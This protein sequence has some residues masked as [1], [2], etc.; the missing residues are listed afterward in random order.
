MV[1]SLRT[2]LNGCTLLAKDSLS[3]KAKYEAKLNADVLG[4]KKGSKYTK[5]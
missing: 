5:V 2:E 4:E 1:R 3:C